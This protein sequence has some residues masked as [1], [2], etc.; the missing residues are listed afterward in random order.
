MEIDK[1]VRIK[2][3]QEEIGKTIFYDDIGNSY[4]AE[5]VLVGKT[6]GITTIKDFVS[7]RIARG[8]LI[9]IHEDNA[10]NVLISLKT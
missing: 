10:R 5:N 3:T 6:Y 7:A 8:L 2:M 1:I 9:D 4:R